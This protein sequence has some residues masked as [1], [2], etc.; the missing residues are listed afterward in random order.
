MKL[1][2][3]FAPLLIAAAFCVQFSNARVGDTK[4]NTLEGEITEIREAEFKELKRARVPDEEDFS[5]EEG[6]EKMGH[7]VGLELHCSLGC[8]HEK[9]GGDNISKRIE[10]CMTSCNQTYEQESG[11]GPSVKEIY[12]TLSKHNCGVEDE[13]LFAFEWEMEA[14]QC[15]ETCTKKMHYKKPCFR[16]CAVRNTH[17]S[18]HAYGGGVLGG[19]FDR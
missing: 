10:A 17:S 2:H 15:R 16:G 8:P 9:F 12:K 19:K 7:D 1:V 13:T 11:D 6:L 4:H 14:H 3:F 5:F 18:K